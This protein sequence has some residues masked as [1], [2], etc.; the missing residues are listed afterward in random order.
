MFGYD[1]TDK[2]YPLNKTRDMKPDQHINLLLIGEAENRHYCLIRNSSRLMN[3][4]TKHHATT[5][6]CYNC[7]HGFAFTETLDQHIELCYKQKTQAIKFPD[8][9]EDKEVS[10]K[11]TKK[12]LPM[13]F[14][15]YADFEAY[16]T[17][18]NESQLGNTTLYQRH[19]PSDSGYMVVRTDPQYT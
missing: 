7:L 4:Q 12:K 16:T 3:Y 6:Y 18:I 11:S 9:P 5:H 14:I 13:P 2:V 19:V 10:F 15:I 17:K 1:K 8:K